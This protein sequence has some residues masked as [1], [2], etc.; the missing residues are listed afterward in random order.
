MSYIT[1][2]RRV[3]WIL[4]EAALKKCLARVCTIY[5]RQQGSSKVSE[6]RDVIRACL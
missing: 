2:Q 1:P 3:G 6:K 5:Y 4:L